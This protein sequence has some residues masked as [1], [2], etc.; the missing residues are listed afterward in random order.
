VQ[1]FAF[2]Q[3]KKYFTVLQMLSNAFTR[4]QTDKYRVWFLAAFI[5]EL[6]IAISRLARQKQIFTL[7]KNE[8]L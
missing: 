7:L 2:D 6:S 8:P 5:F 1:G 4:K 3:F